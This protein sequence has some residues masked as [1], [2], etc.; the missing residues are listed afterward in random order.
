MKY[1]PAMLL[2]ALGLWLLARRSQTR[3]AGKP[4]DLYEE[5]CPTRSWRKDPKTG[6]MMC[7]PDDGREEAF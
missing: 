7:Q 5:P 6:R 3:I 4:E 1:L 2:G